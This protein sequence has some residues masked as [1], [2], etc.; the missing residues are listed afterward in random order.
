MQEMEF[1]EMEYV[2]NRIC[3]NGIHEM[4]YTKMEFVRNGICEK[5]NL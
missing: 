2:R 4:E 3:K 5:W 1:V